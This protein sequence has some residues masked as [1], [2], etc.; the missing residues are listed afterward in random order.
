MC[1]FSNGESYEVISSVALPLAREAQKGWSRP[2]VNRHDIQESVGV[3]CVSARFQLDAL[4]S[5]E[6]L[7]RSHRRQL[8]DVAHDQ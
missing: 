7:S 6:R 8:T 3:P 4:D 5:F 2:S 1:C